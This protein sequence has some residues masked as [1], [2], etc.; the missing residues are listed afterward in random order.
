MRLDGKI[1]VVTGGEMG[2]GAAIAATLSQNGAVVISADIRK[3]DIEQQ[4][5][6]VSSLKFIRCDASL[7]YEVDKAI[8]EIIN[9]Y[10]RIDIVVNNAGI[11]RDI[12]IRSMTEDLWDE[13]INVNLKGTFNWLQGVA[14]YM[15]DQ[16]SGKIVNISSIAYLGNRGTCNYSA[17]KAGINGLTRSAAL[18]LAPFNISVNAIAPGVIGDTELV[19]SLP[20]KVKIKLFSR[21]PCKV[22]GT[23]ID[24]A[25]CVLFLVSD[26]GRYING[27]VIH[28]DGGLTVGYI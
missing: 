7:K 6:G 5:A 23:R 8:S 9:E 15:I 2:I 24:V 1:A 22:P 11:S 19:R 18:E 17:S 20:E 4:Q 16:N 25:N 21:I 3:A 10:R 26:E 12:M 13:V 27:Q 28:V 14:K